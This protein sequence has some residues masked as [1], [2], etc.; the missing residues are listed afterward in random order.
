[1]LGISLDL[2]PLDCYRR[3]HGLSPT[4]G[5]PD[6]VLSLAVER[7]VE[8]LASLGMRGTLFAVGETLAAAEPRR[9]LVGAA[10]AG[11]EIGNHT[12]SHPYDLSRLPPEKIEREIRLAQEAILEAVG[13][14]PVGFRAPGYLL[15]RHVLEKLGPLGIRYDASALPSPAYQTAKAAAVLG[16]WLR[17]RPS[18]AVLGDPREA[19]GPRLPYRPA[20]E[21]PYRRGAAA[22]VE[23]PIS[24]VFGIPLVGG[25]LAWAGPAWARRLGQLVARRPFVHLELHGVDLLDPVRDGIEPELGGLADLRLSLDRKRSS[26]LSFLEGLGNAHSAAPLRD[27]AFKF[28]A[29]EPS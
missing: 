17:G 4:S 2:D 8:L 10:R 13:E 18:Q 21:R 1:M 23:L 14:P 26:I 9:A 28:R 5:G 29:G 24:A 11:H 16:L 7:F 12:W 27:V 3:I 19:F 25:V 6:P 15:G 22:L 20:L